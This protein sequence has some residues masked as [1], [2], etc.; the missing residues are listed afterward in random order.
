L[1][2]SLLALVL[3]CS[4][5]PPPES[6][7]DCHTMQ[8]SSTRDECYAAFVP[9]LFG[10]DPRAAAEVVEERIEDP[11]VRDFVYLQVS[12]D[13]D[14]AGGRWCDRISAEVVAERCHVL[15]RRPHLQR[16]RVGEQSP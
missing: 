7:D 5:S 3:A 15:A 11:L 14:P 16:A 4:T 12:R 13:L 6:L 8:A 2:V 1:L 9:A 10:S